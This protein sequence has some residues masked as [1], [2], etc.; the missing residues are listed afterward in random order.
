MNET[1]RWQTLAKYTPKYPKIPKN[2]PK[3]SKTNVNER[4][5]Q[6]KK[7]YLDEDKDKDKDID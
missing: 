2:A 4:K 1:K 5:K 3:T 6:R 7:L